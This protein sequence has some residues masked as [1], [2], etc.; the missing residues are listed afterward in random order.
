[1]G[2]VEQG[3]PYGVRF[4]EGASLGKAVYEGHDCRGHSELIGHVE[5][6][7]KILVPPG[8]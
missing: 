8:A 3:Y 6:D 5:A 1:M 2:I 4:L 7:P